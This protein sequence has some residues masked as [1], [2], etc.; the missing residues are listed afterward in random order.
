MELAFWILGYPPAIWAY[1]A[2]Y[3]EKWAKNK[4]GTIS[5]TLY[6]FFQAMQLILFL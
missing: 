6:D 3:S 5:P 2:P 4:D 1:T